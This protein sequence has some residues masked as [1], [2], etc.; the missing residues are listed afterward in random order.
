MSFSN[1]CASLNFYKQS[2]KGVVEDYVI[3]FNNEHTSISDVLYITQDLFKQLM[4]KLSERVPRARLI[5]KVC[6]IHI[7]SET[8]EI[9]ER[10]YHF[11]SY[12]T[13]Q[14]LN[15]KEF[16]ERHMEKISTRLDAFIK[17]GS[18]LL[19]KN[20]AHIHIQLMTKPFTQTSSSK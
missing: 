12:Q 2:L 14:V 16:Y 1:D 11:P 19:I 20:I 18:N 15:A 13:E 17:N 10:F 5:A 8:Q 6:F 9:E 3:N 7:N 4:D